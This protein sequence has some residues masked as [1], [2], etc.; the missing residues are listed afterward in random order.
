LTICQNDPYDTRMKLGSISVNPVIDGT[1]RIVP[2]Y[3]YTIAKSGSNTRGLQAED[4]LPHLAGCLSKRSAD[5][6]SAQGIECF[7]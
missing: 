1:A 4:W 5:F 3:A 6:L 7:S 2:G